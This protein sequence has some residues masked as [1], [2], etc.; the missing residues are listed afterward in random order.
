MSAGEMGKTDPKRLA[1]M[2]G[3]DSSGRQFSDE[4]LG[5]VLRH[6]LLALLRTDL[7][8]EAAAAG[9]KT[10]KDLLADPRPALETL[11]R[12]KEFAKEARKAGGKLPEAVATV[13]YFASIAAGL[14][15]CGKRIT[16]LDDNA[17]RGGVEWALGLPWL[18]ESLKGLFQQADKRLK[19]AKKAK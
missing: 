5:A 9:E 10:F 14:L 3:L 16:Q 7:P 12:L 11:T 17:I 8:G 13:L 2:L 19:P 6:Q 15:R 18:D 4:E 1:A